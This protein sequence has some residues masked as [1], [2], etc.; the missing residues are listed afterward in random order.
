M[1]VSSFFST[2][3]SS[4]GRLWLSIVTKCIMVISALIYISGCVEDVCFEEPG[5]EKWERIEFPVLKSGEGDFISVAECPDGN[6]IIGSTGF[7]FKQVEGDIWEKYIVTERTKDIT[8]IVNNGN[9][10]LFAAQCPGGVFVSNDN[11]K[12]WRQVNSR[13]EN[14]YVNDLA[15]SPGGRLFAGTDEGG[16]FVSDDNGGT[17]QYCGDEAIEHR[18]VS[19][20]V[21]SD[22]VLYVGTA[23]DG[24]FR[25]KDNGQTWS[26]ISN[27]IRLWVV[28]DLAACV[29]GSVLVA[30]YTGI[31]KCSSGSDTLIHVGPNSEQDQIGSIM[32]TTDGVVYAGEYRGGVWVSRDDCLTWERSTYGIYNC[33]IYS[34]YSWKGALLACSRNMLQSVDGGRSWRICDWHLGDDECSQGWKFIRG[35]DDGSLLVGNDISGLYVANSSGSSW[36]EVWNYGDMEDLVYRNGKVYS[37]VRLGNLVSYDAVTKNITETEVIDTEYDDL[38]A[39]EIDSRGRIYTGNCKSGIYR[40]SDEGKTWNN[41]NVAFEKDYSEIYPLDIKVKGDSV[42]F[43]SAY[44]DIYR[45]TDD[46]AT[47]KKL[48]REGFSLEIAPGGTIYL[49]G[50]NGILA[51]TD[52][53]DN[54]ELRSSDPI[55][56]M[57]YSPVAVKLSVSANGHMLLSYHAIL[58]HS[59]DGGRSWY[60]DHSANYHDSS[61]RIQDMA[62]GPDGHAY[63]IGESCILRSPTDDY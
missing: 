60:R 53:G 7:V 29:D 58:F 10:L 44:S 62:F 48:D 41:I 32:V 11:G 1:R 35:A 45:S 61:N 36:M 30:S 50:G 12:S 16:I 59:L 63:I 31:Y 14:I 43:V 26:D 56:P 42:I 17:W 9:G 28:L 20:E 27:G 57:T 25:S 37:R 39:L 23:Y 18:V 40:S 24:I 49:C 51:S 4:S 13:L 5:W 15:V 54:W 55:A 47:W 33:R 46:G 52:N 22:S 2:K 38:T 21:V 3:K 6:L 19:I 34:L 8:Q